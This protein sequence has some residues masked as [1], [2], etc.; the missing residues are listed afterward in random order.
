MLCG[1]MMCH[2]VVR[3]FVTPWTIAHQA[4]LSMGF[5]RQKYWSGLPCPLPEDL[6]NPEK[7]KPRSPTLQ[8]DS[9]LSEPPGKGI[10]LLIMPLYNIL[11]V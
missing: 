10:I 11:Y 5:F 8:V 4:P 3:F 7:T 6:P 2:S 9:L 1:A